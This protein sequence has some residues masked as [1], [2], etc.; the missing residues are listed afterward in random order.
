MRSSRR[1]E[2][3][4][5]TVTRSPIW[6]PTSRA[7]TRSSWCT[8]H[9]A[10][11]TSS[12]P[13]SITRRRLSSHRRGTRVAAPIGGRSRSSRWPR[14]EWRTSSTREAPARGNRRDRV[15]G[16]SGRLLVA[17]KKDVRSVSRREDHPPSRR[18]P[19]GRGR[20]PSRCHAVHRGRAVPVHRSAR[21]FDGAAGAQ[22]RRRPGRGGHR[23]GNRRRRAN[24]FT[25][26]CRA[27]SAP[28]TIRERSPSRRPS[29][30][31]SPSITD[32]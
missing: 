22:R 20:E 12:R 28:G 2:A 6:S 27:C 19:K 29:P 31:R 15:S 24:H 32:A 21:P 9:P 17:K 7:R 1:A 13:R 8:A 16:L 5:S 11:Q 4:A 25:S 3:R 18:L 10:R 14:S 30:R 23:R 26:V